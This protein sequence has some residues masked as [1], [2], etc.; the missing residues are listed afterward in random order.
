[1][2]WPSLPA[3]DADRR[4]ACVLIGGLGMGYTAAAALNGLNGDSRVV[5]AELAAAVVKWNRGP[6]ADLAGRPLD[7]DRVTVRQVERGG[8]S[9]G[10]TGGLRRHPL[11]RR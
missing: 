11:G 5:V 1:M 2:P 8:D 4:R 9:S 6:L 10:P 7:S 3:Q